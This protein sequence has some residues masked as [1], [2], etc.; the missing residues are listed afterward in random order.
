MSLSWD[1]KESR[2]SCSISTSFVRVVK[3]VRSRVFTIKRYNYLKE[4]N[5]FKSECVVLMAKNSIATRLL[6][7][8]NIRIKLIC[9]LISFIIF[10]NEF[11]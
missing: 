9:S 2:F 10:F 6:D 1:K 7:K 5:Y 3:I 11:R 8:L 4:Y